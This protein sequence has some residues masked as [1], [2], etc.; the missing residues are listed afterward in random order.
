MKRS[1]V[2]VL[3][4]LFLCC[5][6]RP[7]K[8]F[9][10]AGFHGREY[11]TSVLAERLLNRSKDAVNSTWKVVPRVNPRAL[12]MAERDPEKHA[13]Q[14]VI[15]GSKVDPNRNFPPGKCMHSP[16]LL[17]H[18]LN[19][20]EY[21]GPYPLSE[22]ETQHLANEM[23][24]FAPFDFAFFLHTGTEAVLWPYDSCFR[25]PTNTAYLRAVGRD[26]ARVLEVGTFDQTSHALYLAIGTVSDW[27][28]DELRVPFVYT[29]ET[30]DPFYGS[31][32]GKMRPDATLVRPNMTSEE[33]R[34]FFVPH[35][36]FHRSKLECVPAIDRYVERWERLYDLI[37]HEWHN[38]TKD[39][40]LLQR[41]IN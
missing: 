24:N 11:A 9:V 14:R 1:V 34:L 23:R 35:K 32:H 28:F 36:D 12:E 40:E 33:C 10:A 27:A 19:E 41:L 22:P 37:E 8:V 18:S 25:R 26:I 4:L 21:Q 39:W 30:Y 16:P 29:L 13:C 17:D 38:N 31:C 2:V 7:L 6:G 5:Q 15:P 3:L 20:E